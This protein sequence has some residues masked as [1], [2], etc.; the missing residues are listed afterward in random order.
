MYLKILNT[1][2]L[3]KNEFGK[4]QLDIQP[5]HCY[6]FNINENVFY[7]LYNKGA[8]IVDITYTDGSKISTKNTYI[9]SKI[10]PVELLVLNLN[11]T[12]VKNEV[13]IQRKPLPLVHSK[14]PRLLKDELE[15]TQYRVDEK[16]HDYLFAYPLREDLA[17]VLEFEHNGEN[18]KFTCNGEH[19]RTVL[20]A[21]YDTE[22]KLIY[23]DSWNYVRKSISSIEKK[24]QTLPMLKK[25]QLKQELNDALWAMRREIDSNIETLDM[26]NLIEDIKHFTKNIS[27]LRI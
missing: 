20:N 5:N 23:C 8:K 10:K 17:E 16:V 21:K 27:S 13:V 12:D 19:V 24:V 14:I 18:L 6:E 1:I 15:N 7:M 11:T 4:F 25:A 3:L 9:F 26:H 2:N 22:N